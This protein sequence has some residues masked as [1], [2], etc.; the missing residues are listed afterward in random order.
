MADWFMVG[1]YAAAMLAGFALALAAICAVLYAFL[2]ALAVP[3]I[4]ITERRRERP[5]QP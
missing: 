3:V 4:A 5:G 2:L 1:V